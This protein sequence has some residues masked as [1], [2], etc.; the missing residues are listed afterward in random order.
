MGGYMVTYL[1]IDQVL[2]LCVGTIPNSQA[3]EHTT[4]V[5]VVKVRVVKRVMWCRDVLYLG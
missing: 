2:V 5:R 1:N 3:T 4:R